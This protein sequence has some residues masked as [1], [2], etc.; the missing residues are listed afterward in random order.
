MIT[1]TMA[2]CGV[3]IVPLCLLLFLSLRVVV[4]VVLW[5]VLLLMAYKVFTM[6][7]EYTEYDPYSILELDSV[8]HLS[9]R[10]P[11]ATVSLSLSLFPPTFILWFYFL[12]SCLCSPSSSL[13]GASMGEIRKQYRKLSKVYHPDKEGGDQEKFMQIAKAYEA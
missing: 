10:N 8:C 4:L 5:G 1:S 2:T 11:L 13:Q 12:L 3:L 7:R 9:D 6:E